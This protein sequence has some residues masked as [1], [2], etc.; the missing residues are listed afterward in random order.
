MFRRAARVPYRRR[1]NAYRR[2][3]LPRRPSSNSIIPYITR[4]PADL[5]TIRQ[6]PRRYLKVYLDILTSPAG[7]FHIT[8]AD[9]RSALTDGPAGFHGNYYQVTGLDFWGTPASLGSTPSRLHLKDYITGVDG[10]DRDTGPTRPRVGL[11]Y[12]QGAQQ[13]LQSKDDTLIIIEGTSIPVTTV[14]TCQALVYAICW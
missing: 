13:V 12:P 10:D 3:A 11:R 14:S 6:N 5:P 8:G 1:R 9:I 7:L 2:R 4:P